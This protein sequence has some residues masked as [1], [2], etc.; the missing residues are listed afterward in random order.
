MSVIMRTSFKISSIESIATRKTG[1][2]MCF[3]ALSL[4]VFHTASIISWLVPLSYIIA[5]T[6]LYLRSVQ[7][8]LVV[9]K[10]K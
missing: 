6:R 9:D 5:E 2:Q 10:W 7:V 1:L 8:G 4:T 3:V